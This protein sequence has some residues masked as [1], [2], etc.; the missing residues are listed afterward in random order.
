M[1]SISRLRVAV[2]AGL[3]ALSLAAC[4]GASATGDAAPA[5]GDGPRVLVTDLAYQPETLTVTAGT[6]VT[7]AFD[8]GAV[9]HDVVGDGFASEL[10]ADGTFSHTFETPGTYAYRCTLHPSMTGTVEVTR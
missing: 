9:R 5:G 10:I 6:T 7:W 1:V 2:A 3:L 8:D 4:G